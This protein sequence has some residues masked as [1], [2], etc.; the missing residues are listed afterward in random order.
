MIKQCPSTARVHRG[1]GCVCVSIK[2]RERNFTKDR[3]IVHEILIYIN[4]I[5]FQG[6]CSSCRSNDINWKRSIFVSMSDQEE[7]PYTSVNKPPRPYQR[8]LTACIHWVM[9]LKQWFRPQLVPKLELWSLSRSCFTANNIACPL[10][11]DME[12]RFRPWPWD[13]VYFFFLLSCIFSF[14]I[15]FSMLLL[16]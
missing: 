3:A 14:N 16:I 10:R 11:M 15:G 9:M 6:C 5:F 13:D 8:W 1:R 4:C 7:D 12:K 2:E